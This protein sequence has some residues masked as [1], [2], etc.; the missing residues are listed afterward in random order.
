MLIHITPRIYLPLYDVAP[1]ELVDVHVP[2]FGIRLR[3]GRDVVT[4]TP[5]P[6][7]GH[8]VGARTPDGLGLIFETAD[9]VFRFT[10]F[11]R[12]A[13]N[14]EHVVT[15]VVHY[16]VLDRDMDSVSDQMSLWYRFDDWDFRVPVRSHA[17][18]PVLAEPRMDFL[19]EC[20]TN[21]GRQGEVSDLYD[22]NGYI[23]RRTENF[24]LP[25][26]ERGRLESRAA[27]DMRIPDATSAFRVDR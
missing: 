16:F 8:F 4:G 11:S 22:E 6:N 17:D 20:I 5:C 19:P 26:I 21:A 10:A 2:S 24:Y 13:I 12:W 3:G 9:H 15:H 23:V 1:P 18:I 25:T 7:K 27:R 14:A